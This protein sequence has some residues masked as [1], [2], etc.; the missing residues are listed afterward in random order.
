MLCSFSWNKR[1]KKLTARKHGVESLKII[2]AQE[3][4]LI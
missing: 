4:K 1:K 2:E 3:A